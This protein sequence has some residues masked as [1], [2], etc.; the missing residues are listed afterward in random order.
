MPW[1][2][3]ET[4]HI[5]SGVSLCHGVCVCEIRRQRLNIAFLFLY[6]DFTIPTGNYEYEN[7]FHIKTIN[8]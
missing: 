6:T 7:A 2:V 1:Y 4:G 5:L 3:Y 8:S